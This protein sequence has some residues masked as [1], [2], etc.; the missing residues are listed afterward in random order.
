MEEFYDEIYADKNYE[1]ECAFLKGLIE[2]IHP[3]AES[4]LDVACGTGKHLEILQNYF[5]VSGSDKNEKML[6]IASKRTNASLHLGDMSDL[7]LGSK[8]DVI[9]CL[10]GSIGYLLSVGRLNQ[11]VKKFAEH[12]N[13]DGVLILEPF[14]YPSWVEEKVLHRRVKDIEITSRVTKQG[15][16]CQLEKTFDMPSGVKN[17]IYKLAMFEHCEYEKALTEAGFCVKMS[18]C[19]EDFRALYIGRK[20]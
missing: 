5:D 10:F 3:N 6:D 14:A 7:R 16:V 8:F 19:P 12:L 1:Q 17:K 15:N 2:E 11:A 9:M 20:R 4:L 13:E 18:P